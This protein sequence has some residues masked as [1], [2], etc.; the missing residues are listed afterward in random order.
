M[1]PILICMKS[2][3]ELDRSAFSSTDEISQC[4]KID[5]LSVQESLKLLAVPSS[6]LDTIFILKG[7]GRYKLTYEEQE[8]LIDSLL[9]KIPEH[10]YQETSTNKLV[11]KFLKFIEPIISDH[12]F[13]KIVPT[14]PIINFEL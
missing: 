5:T 4:C 10:S 7:R 11:Q 8:K 1:I 3:L 12:R 14:K 6:R 2:P 13:W 9:A